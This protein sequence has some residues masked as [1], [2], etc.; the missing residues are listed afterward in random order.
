MVG[1]ITRLPSKKGFGQGFL[2]KDMYKAS[3]ND[4]ACVNIERKDSEVK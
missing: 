1:I 2:E 3:E 4:I